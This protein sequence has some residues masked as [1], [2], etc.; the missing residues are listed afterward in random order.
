M[1]SKSAIS[2]YYTNCRSLLPKIDELRMLAQT[3]QPD[4]LAMTETWLDQDIKQSE[5]AIPS[6]SLLRRDRSRH[7]GGICLY[8]NNSL[9]FSS[10]TLLSSSQH[11]WRFSV[12]GPALS[13]RWSGLIPV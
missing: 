12:R 13:T 9:A 11:H 5:L 6:Y 7:E 8:I 2:F 10:K 3:T 1:L 4:L